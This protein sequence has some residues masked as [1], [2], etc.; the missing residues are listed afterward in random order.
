MKP[1]FKVLSRE[2][3]DIIY[4]TALHILGN[5]GVNIEDDGII[6][7]LKRNGCEATPDRIVY[8]PDWVVEDCLKSSPKTIMLCGR[9]PAKDMAFGKPDYPYIISHVLMNYFDGLTNTYRTITKEDVRDFLVISDYLE[10]INGVWILTMMPEFKEMYMY[11]DYEMGI[12]NTTKPICLSNFEPVSINPAYELAAAIVGG[13]D[14]LKRRPLTVAFCEVSPLTWNK[15]GCEMLKATARSGIQ[16]VVTVETPMGDTG[17]ITFAGNM[18][19]KIA[20]LLSGLVILQLL[21]KGIPTFFV[22]PHETFDMRTA[23]VNL[24]G[25]GDFVYG[26]AIG[27]IEEYLG[28]PVV[29]PVSPD[30]HLLD[31]QECYELGFS[32]LPQMLS[33]ARSVVV[34]G[35]DTTRAINNELLLLL[36]DMVISAQRILDGIDVSRETLAVDVIRDVCSKIEKNRRCGHFLDQRHTLKYYEKEHRPRKDSVFEKHR[37]EKWMDLGSKSFI[38]RAHERVQEILKTHKPEPISKELEA[39][40]AEIHTKYKIPSL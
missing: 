17:P 27:Q 12:R 37:R 30:S 24:A 4:S 20:E 26:C 22:A 6:D 40:I 3:L 18:A 14:E 38:Q 10:T 11:C 16:P 15:Y 29:T 7:L 1:R 31:M 13:E 9:D 34:H 32:L 8:Y 21:K 5:I 39:K 36:D 28:I 33:G 23:Q 25:R 2:E 35:L 19:Q